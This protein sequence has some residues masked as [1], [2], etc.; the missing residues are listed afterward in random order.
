M[1][2]VLAGVRQHVIIGDVTPTPEVQSGL[3][4]CLRRSGPQGFRIP[5][6]WMK[7]I[8]KSISTLPATWHWTI[9]EDIL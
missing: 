7:K 4:T 9:W 6:L 5:P 2:E 3:Q 8:S 1:D